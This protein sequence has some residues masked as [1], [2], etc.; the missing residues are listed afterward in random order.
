MNDITLPKVFGCM[1]AVVLCGIGVAALVMVYAEYA[2]THWTPDRKWVYLGAFTVAT[3]SIR[4]QKF[5]P[6][7]RRRS[8]W[9]AITGIA[10]VH[11]VGYS[12]VLLR[13]DDWRLAWSVMVA[14]VEVH[15]ISQALLALGYD[16]NLKSD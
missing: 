4:I 12:I 13:I 14:F 11:L 16:F 9:F 5:R 15:M 7:W 8:F 3:F 1:I 2:R 6:S 10:A